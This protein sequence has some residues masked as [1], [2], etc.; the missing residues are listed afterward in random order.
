[1]RKAQFVRDLRQLNSNDRF[2]S[3]FLVRSKERRSKKNGKPFLSVTLADRT[4]E[5]DTK[6]WDNVE[7]LDPVFKADDFVRVQGKVQIYNDKHQ[8]VAHRI[9]VLPEEHVSLADFVPHTERDIGSMY[10]EVLG[11]IE[12]FSNADLKR[13]MESIFRD[14]EFAAMYKR[15]P[16]AKANHHAKVGGLLEHVVSVL[17]LGKLVASHYED[18]D[19]DLLA[20]GV[21]LHD[22]GKVFE[23][24]SGRSFDYTDRGRLL[25]HIAMGS[26]WVERRC[27]AL[28]GFPP[29]L[30]TLLLHLVLSHHGK[31][32]FGSP[33]VP[34][35]PEALA[36]HAIDDLDAKLEMMRQ[37]RAQ[38][39]EGSV[40]SGYHRRLDRF[41]LDKDAYLRDDAPGIATADNGR[42][43]DGPT[44]AAPRPADTQPA[45]EPPEPESA[46]P[47][48]VP[49]SAP[50]PDPEPEVP[51]EA[52]QA[53]E[54]VA[55]GPSEAPI[56]SAADGRE[57]AEAAPE[58]TPPPAPAEA[59]EPAE[60]AAE[61]ADA[62][63]PVAETV[64]AVSEAPADPE[65]PGAAEIPAASGEP[66]R[67]PL[68]PPAPRKP[69]TVRRAAP[70][71]ALPQPPPPLPLEAPPLEETPPP[72]DDSPQQ[73]LFSPP[74]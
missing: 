67:I 25:G 18:V 63:A 28:E 20:C 35:F 6:V 74:G 57:P 45:P 53:P 73:D 65:A 27:D 43:Q 47:A 51:A 50:D 32:E 33:Q 41:V 2:E 36:L 7:Q 4:G 48:P 72:E 54:P 26:A 12:R 46:V 13:L 38:T 15:A 30:K 16:A 23:L 52:P 9:L 60:A 69:T 58:G 55:A 22:L 49:A 10:E 62:A 70:P 1:M 64:A 5:I 11:T 56:D 17:R 71:A 40:W 42:P 21:L 8:A 66:E 34:L 61:G 14:P 59:Q 31:F 37:A 29:R 68:R 3:D 39:V 24:D 19:S 44:A